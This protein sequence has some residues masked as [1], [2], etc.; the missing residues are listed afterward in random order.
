[1]YTINTTNVG[2]NDVITEEAK[3]LVCELIE[4]YK[5][6]EGK[7][8]T[9][10][11]LALQ[12]IILCL[13]LCLAIFLLANVLA[14]TRASKEAA[15]NLAQTELQLEALQKSID[16]LGEEEMQIK[17]KKESLSESSTL[18]IRDY[19]RSLLDR[20]ILKGDSSENT[21]ADLRL[22]PD[23]FKN[24]IDKLRR[25]YKVIQET[26]AKKIEEISR[27]SYA[28]SDK[29]KNT[30]LYE[31]INASSTRVGSI[32]IL[33]FMVQVFSRI[34][35]YNLKLSDFYASRA[36]AL[37]LHLSNR[38]DLSLE[39]IVSILSP[40]TIDIKQQKLPTSQM[41]DLIKTTLQTTVKK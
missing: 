7:Q 30:N 31:F 19:R 25:N 29:N 14:E 15:F 20:I 22:H 39:R 3:A 38:P 8:R 16:S 27:I 32:L 21:Y 12:G 13:I 17:Y 35:R 10:A 2:Q 23:T 41:L 9:N 6:R 34:H 40:D 1:M 24:V 37:K 18:D 26:K 33:I 36:N 5:K 11:R 28:L 4:D